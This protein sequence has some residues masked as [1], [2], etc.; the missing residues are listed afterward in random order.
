MS[1]NPSQSSLA[2]IFDSFQWA[3]IGIENLLS[4]QDSKLLDDY[5]TLNQRLETEILKKMPSNNISM[6][7]SY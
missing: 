6:L 4:L 5:P 3:Y 7:F 2:E 1:L